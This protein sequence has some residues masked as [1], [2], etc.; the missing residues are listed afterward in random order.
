MIIL[1]LLTITAGG[2]APRDLPPRTG[3]S[4][5]QDAMRSGIR[6]VARGD[7]DFDNYFDW[8]Y[9]P[10]HGKA[11]PDE[12]PKL[13][14]RAESRHQPSKD[15][16]WKTSDQPQELNDMSHSPDLVRRDDLREDKRHGAN[17]PP[18]DGGNDP[19]PIDPR[20][21]PWYKHGPHHPPASDA[22]AARKKRTVHL[23]ARSEDDQMRRPPHGDF[24]RGQ[25]QAPPPPPPPGNGQRGRDATFV[26]LQS[27]EKEEEGGKDKNKA[28]EPV[29]PGAD[30]PAPAAGDWMLFLSAQF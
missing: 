23:A 16:L 15:D 12:H 18:D 20:P 22:E 25:E 4:S 10:G 14:R 5:M 19:L 8:F 27:V 17:T 7:D 6:L 11:K 28:P 26:S 24:Q 29:A 9:H 30:K 2:D 13:V 21:D 3:H 1:L